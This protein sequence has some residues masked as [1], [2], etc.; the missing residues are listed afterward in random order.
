MG[1]GKGRAPKPV[2]PGQASLDYVQGMSDPA[3]QQRLLSAEQTFRPQ[4]EELDLASINRLLQGAAGHPGL[5]EQLGRVAPEMA[6]IEAEAAGVQ[7]EA[8]V[9][10]VERLLPRVTEAQR[11]ADPELHGLRDD[12]L[13]EARREM[14]LGGR[15]S[16]EEQRL[17][18]QTAREAG[19]ARGRGLDQGT[20]AGEVLN[21]QGFA[22][23]R[24]DRARQFGL[25]AAGMGAGTATDPFMAILG[26][27]GQGA[28]Q[29]G[30]M[31]GQGY[32]M[33][34]QLG[35]TLFNPDAG[36][37]LALG[38]QANM[39]NYQAARAGGEGAALGG[40][41]AGAGAIAG[42]MM[43]SD[44]RAKAKIVRV[45][46]RREGPGI[47]TFVY[48]DDPARTRRVG[49]MADEAAGVWPEAVRRRADGF[50]GIDYALVD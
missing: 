31:L 34:G 13:G 26:R 2:D 14:A 4:Y 25:G 7:R 43:L 35:P 37:N 17:A 18:T 21:R 24:Q 41:L 36:V 48:R 1:G 29:A 44:R 45:G 3:L 20:M 42:A 9:A 12:L 5:M 19:V 23:A 28:A 22:D 6:G 30:G 46:S 11:A 16:P 8:D 32:Q 50:L 10:D 40:A 38:Q 47:Y 39:A 49:M 33:T 15:L 27:P